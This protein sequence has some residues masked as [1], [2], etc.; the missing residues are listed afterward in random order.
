MEALTYG[1]LRSLALLHR[2]GVEGATDRL[3]AIVRDEQ[4]ALPVLLGF[5]A[6]N[7]PRLLRAEDPVAVLAATIEEAPRVARAAR[8]R[9]EGTRAQSIAG[10]LAG[11]LVLDERGDCELPVHD[12]ALITQLGGR[13]YVTF[14]ER[15]G[16]PTRRLRDLLRACRRVTSCV[17]LVRATT[18]DVVYETPCSRGTVR[19]HLSPA[20]DEDAIV[21]PVPVKG[22]APKTLARSPL[23]TTVLP[24]ASSRGAPQPPRSLSQRFF[25]ALLVAALGGST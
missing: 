25:E 9:E 23:A 1:E 22:A 5:P 8:S 16:V 24:T 7:L 20:P 4:D 11:R 14:G 18:L 15:G 21:V 2:R 12:L 13:R 6:E 17:V 19:L 3:L 10:E